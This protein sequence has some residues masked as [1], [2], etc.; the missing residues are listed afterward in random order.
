MRTLLALVAF[1]V[2]PGTYLVP[3]QPSTPPASAATVHLKPV[4]AQVVTERMHANRA[5]VVVVDPAP[6]Y[7][8]GLPAWPDYEYGTD[9]VRWI[10]SEPGLTFGQGMIAGGTW[11][12]FTFAKTGTYTITFGSNQ[13][14]GPITADPSP[15]ALLYK[16]DATKLV[17]TV[18]P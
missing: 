18:T 14:R 1:G 8:P 2:I 6:A 9:G 12:R 11:A 4:C 16:A 3:P 15:A 13:C 10:T 5:L 17:V 7:R